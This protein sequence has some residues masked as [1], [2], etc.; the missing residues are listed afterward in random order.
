MSSYYYCP[1]TKDDQLV[2]DKLSELSEL[3]RRWGFWMMYHRLRRL[4]YIW[5]HKK[6]YRIYTEMGLNLRRKNK[7]R[8]PS[9]IEEP[10]VVP[11]L[12]NNTWSM[13]FMHDSLANGRRFRSLNVIDDY[14]REI[15]NITVGSSISSQRVI[16]QLDQ[17]ISWRGKPKYIRVDNG[18]EF[19]SN[20]LEQWADERDIVLKFIEKGKP[21]QNGYIERF[22]KSYRNEVLDAY[23]FECQ[24][25]D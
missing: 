4:N 13:Y 7:K 22:N 10:L 25:R 9:R 8:L 19:I 24:H 18:P 5:N 6:V 3:H 21:Y 2:R 1:K 15:L 14:N 16:R 20:A 23:A 12:P 17:L 11:E